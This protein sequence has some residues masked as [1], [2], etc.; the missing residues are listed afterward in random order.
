MGPANVIRKTQ[1]NNIALSIEHPNYFRV[2]QVNCLDNS[3]NAIN[4]MIILNGTH[5][6]FELLK[7]G[8]V[9]APAMVF[10]VTSL[11]ELPNVIPQ[12][13]GFFPLDFMIN[14]PRPALLSDF[15]GELSVDSF[16]IASSSILDITISSQKIQ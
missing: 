6:A 1:G 2:A 9:N 10:P 15:I 13:Q 5:R 16:G 3:G 14:C 11:A 8:H 7:A 4:R 12:G